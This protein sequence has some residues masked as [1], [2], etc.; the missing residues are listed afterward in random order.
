MVIGLDCAEPDLVLN[1]WLTKSAA[2]EAARTKP[3]RGVWKAYRSKT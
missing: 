3:D 2:Y 1:R